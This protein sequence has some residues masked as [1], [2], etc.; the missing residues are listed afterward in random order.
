MEIYSAAR[1]H[2]LEH[3]PVLMIVTLCEPRKT[4]LSIN[5]TDF[6]NGTNKLSSPC[7]CN[8]KIYTVISVSFLFFLIQRSF[9]WNY[10]AFS[11]LWEKGICSCY[12][13]LIPMKYFTFS[14][15]KKLLP[16]YTVNWTRK[17]LHKTLWYQKS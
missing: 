6:E 8:Q 5:V 4:E 11:K 15:I 14:D 9:I 3:F 7:G 17:V 2:L 13:K 10:Y 16:L 12:V 1:R